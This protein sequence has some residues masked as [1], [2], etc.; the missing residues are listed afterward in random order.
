MKQSCVQQANINMAEYVIETVEEDKREET[1]KQVYH[2]Y[3]YR[4]LYKEFDEDEVEA[5]NKV[6]SENKVEA[7]NEIE[8]ENKVEAENDTQYQPTTK[9]K[10]DGEQYT[11]DDQPSIKRKCGENII[12]VDELT[13]MFESITL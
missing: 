11:Q 4:K 1:S 2:F 7:E 10:F 9:R 8:A 3:N 12:D 5:E 13:K 6:E